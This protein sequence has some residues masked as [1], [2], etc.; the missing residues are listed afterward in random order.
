MGY[1][2]IVGRP[3]KGG[4]FFFSWPALVASLKIWRMRIR[5][6]RL[7]ILKTL[8]I[9]AMLLG[10]GAC[11]RGSVF[12]T[13]QVEFEKGLDN[14][15]P[16]PEKCTYVKLSY[17]VLSGG[18]KE[19]RDKLNGEIRSF[20]F[21]KND[22]SI[23]KDAEAWAAA[24]FNEYK[25]FG[26]QIPAAWWESRAIKVLANTPQVFSASLGFEGYSGG[27]HPNTQVDYRS[28]NPSNGRRYALYDWLKKGYEAP[29]Q[30]LGEK[31]FRKARNLPAGANLNDAGFTFD[32]GFQ[33]ND[34]Y[35][36]TT[37]G[38]VFYFNPYEIASY[39]DGPTELTI[40][41]SELKAW[42]LPKGPL[43]KLANP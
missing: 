32:Q 30:E 23:A 25:Q 7:A 43:A 31:A 19:G 10:A 41:Y 21:S 38:L 11:Q 37:Q 22:D 33:L 42:L 34:N 15:K 27:A 18:S 29:L 24:F 5:P 13:E 2:A 17:P 6:S 1:L 28:Y 26:G 16:A 9:V 8:L 4:K 39:A 40:P 14:C 20:A 3:A 36:A 35:A 12:K